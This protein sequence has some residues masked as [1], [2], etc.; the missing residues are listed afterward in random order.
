M[1]LCKAGTGRGGGRGGEGVLCS[2]LT[3]FFFSR[4]SLSRW[5]G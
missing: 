4:P 2:D 3:K 1:F 5:D